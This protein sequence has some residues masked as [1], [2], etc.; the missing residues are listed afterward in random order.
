MVGRESGLE[1]SKG[2][3]LSRAW[4]DTSGGE[5]VVSWISLVNFDRFV[6]EIVHFLVRIVVRIALGIKGAHAGAVLS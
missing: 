1:L 3:L 6:E 2:V 4:V 5:Q